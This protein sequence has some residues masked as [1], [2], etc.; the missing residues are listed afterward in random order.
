MHLLVCGNGYL[1]QAITNIFRSNYWKV[2]TT[3]LNGNDNNIACDL[4][5]IESVKLLN[6]INPDAIIHCASSGKGGAIAYENVYLNGIKNL[7]T[8]FP[9]KKI[10]YTSST[11]VYAQIDGSI[12]NEKSPTNPERDTG[13]I[14]LEAEKLTLRHN[15]IV[16]RLSGIYGPGRSSILNKFLNK[17]A[18]IEEQ[19]ERL[20]NQI[21][22]DDAASA[23]YFLLT[24]KPE[25]TN[26]IFIISDNK[27]LTQQTV[28][29]FLASY[30]SKP[31]PPSGPRDLNRKRGW[32]NKQLSNKKLLS[33]G[34][35]PNYSSF[36]DAIKDLSNTF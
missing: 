35:K 18:I 27:S 4:S 21:H 10:L 30:F 32:T 25:I 5:D 28:Y 8:I 1:G 17:E 9:N 23:I 36:V 12:V 29:E 2:T 26:E 34:W 15:G 7:T 13:K 19:G 11:S 22:R 14:L 33:L 24:H 3:T 20:L 6:S 31:F 16:C